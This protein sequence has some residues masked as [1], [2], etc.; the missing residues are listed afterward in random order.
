M[1]GFTT[2]PHLH[3]NAKI[4]TDKNGLISTK[5]EFESGIKGEDLKKKDRVK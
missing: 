3:F 1:T 5:I 4:P 2:T